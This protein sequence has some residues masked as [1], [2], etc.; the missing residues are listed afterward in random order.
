MSIIT[1]VLLNRLV[2]ALLSGLGGHAATEFQ[3]YFSAFCKVVN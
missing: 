2:I 3:S 1:G